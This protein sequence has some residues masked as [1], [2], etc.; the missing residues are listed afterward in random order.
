LQTCA[1]AFKFGPD[2]YQPNAEVIIRANERELSMGWPSG[3]VSPLIPTGRD[4]FIDRSYWEDF[5]IERDAAGHPTAI[6][7]GEFRGNAVTRKGSNQS[8]VFLP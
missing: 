1:G 5:S 2:F 4:H 3:D 7:Y 6:V 8:V